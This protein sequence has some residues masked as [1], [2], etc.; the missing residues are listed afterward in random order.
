MVIVLF[1]LFMVL[2]IMLASQAVLQLVFQRAIA[3]ERRLNVYAVEPSIKHKAP[4]KKASAKNR[5]TIFHKPKK[6]VGHLLSK[7]A[8]A[9]LD[10]KLRDAGMSH[11]WNAVDYRLIQ[12]AISSSLFLF[13]LLFLSQQASSTFSLVMLSSALGGLGYYYMN[14]TLS[15]KKSK[16]IVQVQK[17]MA[18]FFDMIT[19]S[20]EA[21]M[22]LD[23]SLQKA[24]QQI[25]GPLSEEFL[26][27]L[28]EMKLGK[29]RREAF[30]N[31]KNRIPAPD[32]QGIMTS[33]I[34]ADQ[35]G[36]GMGKALR[37]ITVR[38]REQQKQLAK[39]KAMKAPVKMLF[40]MVF[41]IF[42]A[43]FIILLGPL[44]IYF[45]QNGFN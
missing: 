42:P 16:R 38:V 25:K 43:L 29:S 8:K 18:D 14:F 27:A 34:Q 36:I 1:L 33:L 31:L 30:S 24:C 22:G 45:V 26:K 7:E 3:L 6:L 21:G 44:V 41:F 11:R 5:S 2:S 13:S 9:E 12:L 39:E 32:F 35:L 17:T 10:K 40:P 28:E 37:T 15:V 20:L 4:N 23:A 19:L